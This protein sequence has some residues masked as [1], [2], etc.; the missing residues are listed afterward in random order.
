MTF[1]HGSETERV[2]GGSVPVSVV[3]SAII[4][5]VGTAPIGAV[6]ELTVCLTKKILPNSARF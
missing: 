4:G 2:N 6:N 1:H 3:D 5:I